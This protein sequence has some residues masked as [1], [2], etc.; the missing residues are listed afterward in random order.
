LSAGPSNGRFAHTGG[1]GVD[2][3]SPVPLWSQ[4]LEDLRSRLGS[5]EFVDD[6]PS[7]VQLRDHYLVSR[8]TVREALRRLQQ[9]GLIERGRG[10]GTFVKQRPIEQ[11]LGT[12]YSL[13][14]SAEEQGFE[15]RSLVRFLETRRDAEA[16]G[17]LGCDPSEPLVYL[18]RLRLI[19]GRPVVLDCS[20]LPGRLAAPLL[21]ADFTHTALYKEMELR[22][23][24]RPD[25]G[26]EQ[27]SPLLPTP[28]QR[29][30]LGLKARAPAYCIE[31]LACQGRMRVEW[32]HGVIRADRFRF[33]A[34]WGDGRVDAAFEPP[35]TRRS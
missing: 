9:E 32:R 1:V 33:V 27:V 6:F 25:S 22:C 12:L 18:E 24:L 19:D 34:R 26:W 2:R 11:Q 4:V 13:Y 16:A 8:Q 30:L 14:R 15:Q 29:E 5:G 17:M 28:Q 3:D 10:R 23:G 20:W 21:D 31:R 35:D 7:D